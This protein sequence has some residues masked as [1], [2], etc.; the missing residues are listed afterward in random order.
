MIKPTREDFLLTVRKASFRIPEASPV[1]VRREVNG[2]TVW[3]PHVT[4]EKTVYTR[5]ADSNLLLTDLSFR[6]AAGLTVL[7]EL[8]EYRD[9]PVVS[10]ESS[11]KN[12]SEAAF[13]V[14]RMIAFKQEFC[15]DF[16]GLY[17][18]GAE[19][20]YLPCYTAGN[21]LT[22]EF[23]DHTVFLDCPGTAASVYPTPL[24]VEVLFLTD[25]HVI[26]PQGEIRLPKITVMVTEGGRERSAALF[27]AFKKKHC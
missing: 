24:G 23:D 27:A 5:L 4:E 17:S 13:A 21:A 11:V 18:S 2:E 9:Y 3:D 10:V 7:T 20:A 15:G 25:D 8:T 16:C 26:P 12:P 19:D 1:R 22:L 6:N 14:Q